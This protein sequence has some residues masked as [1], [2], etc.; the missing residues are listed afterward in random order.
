MPDLQSFWGQIDLNSASQ[1]N[2]ISEGFIDFLKVSKTEWE[3]RDYIIRRLLHFRFTEL[4]SIRNALPGTGFILELDDG[5]VAA[6]V[7]GASN[8][9]KRGLN[10]IGCPIDVETLEM[11]QMSPAT[12][13]DSDISTVRFSPS[14][15]SISSDWAASNVSIHGIRSLRDRTYRFFSIG[16]SRKEP[17]YYILPVEQRK[18]QDGKKAQGQ[19][20]LVVGI[21]YTRDEKN[22]KPVY[23][24][25]F[26]SAVGIDAKNLGSSTLS[27]VGADAPSEIGADRSLI[28]GFGALERVSVYAAMKMLTDLTRP[29]DTIVV[30]FH[31]GKGK[32]SR[33]G[34]NREITEKLAASIAGKIIETPSETAALDILQF[35][36]IL[37]MTFLKA[38]T[39]K[40]AD[41]AAPKPIP[42]GRGT[43]VGTYSK[44]PRSERLLAIIEDSLEKKAIPF[45]KIPKNYEFT[46]SGTIGK[47]FPKLVQEIVSFS[48]VSAGRRGIYSTVSKIDLW[49]AY[50][51]ILAYSTH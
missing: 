49:A 33:K 44:S 39:S 38:K 3:V 24:D 50:R 48:Q 32:C 29:E 4:A 5:C 11:N 51:A 27:L 30:I 17:R 2:S 19:Y 21:S 10:L 14:G 8:I 16:E 40:P 42:A 26:L 7:F 12:I 22:S 43:V 6:G 1:I 37:D 20:D 45:Q 47:E 31:S 25:A 41:G 34:H 9:Q 15:S 18:G 13:P 46:S 36:R 23:P 28:Q 35:S